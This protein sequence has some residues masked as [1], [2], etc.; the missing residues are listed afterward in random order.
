MGVNRSSSKMSC[1]RAQPNVYPRQERGVSNGD[2]ASV[3]G[4]AKAQSESP[5]LG[6]DTEGLGGLVPISTRR[7]IH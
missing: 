3:A 2:M 6:D 7:G 4:P 1:L 5:T